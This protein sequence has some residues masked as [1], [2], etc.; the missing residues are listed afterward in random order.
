MRIGIDEARQA[1]L[2]EV[3]QRPLTC[4]ATTG[5][6]TGEQREHG[7]FQHRLPGRQLVEFL[8]H[9]DAIRSRVLDRLALQ[10]N[11]AVQRRQE[12][13]HRLE[14][15]GLAAAGRA[16]QHETVGAMHLEGHLVRGPHPALA[17]AVFDVEIL[18][19][20]QRLGLRQGQVRTGSERSVHG[21]LLP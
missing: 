10:A 4:L 20:Q 9:H 6:A 14:Q 18:H 2:V 1:D 11:L 8:E 13:R 16:E 7:V 19:L 12:A 17:G 5:L 3:M 15:A 21:R